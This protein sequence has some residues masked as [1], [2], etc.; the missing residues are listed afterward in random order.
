[1]KQISRLLF[2]AISVFSS[3]YVLAADPALTIAELNARIAKIGIPRVQ[4]T[5]VVAGKT[6]PALFIGNRKINGNYDL[7]DTVRKDLGVVATVFVKDG[8]E[9]IRVSTNA[10]TPEGRRGVGTLLAHN[11][12][13]EAL[14]HGK[15]F[16]GVIDVLGTS[17]N[18]CYNP[19]LNGAGQL[20]AASYVGHRT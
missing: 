7:V 14:S 15:S 20:I 16:C 4:G 5:D 2:L 1:M 3:P 8:D 19:I 17:L 11:K 13:Y 10:M 6:V 18:S 12:A 9:F